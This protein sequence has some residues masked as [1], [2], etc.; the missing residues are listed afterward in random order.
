MDR[1]EYEPLAEIAVDEVSPSRQ[2]FTLSGQ[3]RD[4]SRR[5][6]R[7]KRRKQ[8]ALQGLSYQQ[9]PIDTQVRQPPPTVRY[10]F[11][12]EVEISEVIEDARAPLKRLPN[13]GP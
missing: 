9:R 2:G 4:Q 12:C 3:G 8:A 1:P 6:R 10:P 11:V 5:P 7:T 13:V